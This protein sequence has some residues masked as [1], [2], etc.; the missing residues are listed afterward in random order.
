MSYIADNWN[1]NI[2]PESKITLEI[3][4]EDSGQFVSKWFIFYDNPLS[5]WYFLLSDGTTTNDAYNTLIY[6]S[7]KQDA[8][9]CCEK[10]GYGWVEL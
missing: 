8:I 6:F 2:Q 9:D 7:T 10:Y 3:T 4:Q 5:S 1:T